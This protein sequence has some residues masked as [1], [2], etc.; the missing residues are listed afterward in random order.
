MADV[1]G[2]PASTAR[3]F[4]N[5]AASVVE[6]RRYVL[7]ALG[8]VAPPVSEV[9]AV[10]VSELATNAVRHTGSAIRGAGRSGR[11]GDPRPVTDGGPGTPT[12]R[13]PSPTQPS[14]RG[15]QI[16][17]ALASDWGVLPARGG[18]GKTVWFAIAV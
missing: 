8:E 2:V 11:R 3:T 9:V 4:P 15:L 5:D 12:V 10:L 14:G 6:A 18:Q 7:A 16:V 13:T 1:D 17:Q